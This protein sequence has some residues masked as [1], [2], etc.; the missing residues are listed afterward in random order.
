MN[1][2]DL[3]NT[4]TNDSALNN[5][6]PQMNT[7]EMMWEARRQKNKKLYTILRH[8]LGRGKHWLQ[9]KTVAKSVQWK[10]RMK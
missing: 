6:A 10:S 2:I 1:N 4:I 7:E 9:K 8:K 5:E 3:N